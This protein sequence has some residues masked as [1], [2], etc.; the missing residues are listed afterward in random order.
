MGALDDALE[1]LDEL[2]DDNTLPKNVRGSVARIIEH[3]KDE[4]CE[5]SIRVD[6]AMQELEEISSDINV[7]AYSRTQLWHVVSML[8]NAI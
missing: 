7:Q 2:K 3:L 4:T 6:K 5:L 8:E 1:I